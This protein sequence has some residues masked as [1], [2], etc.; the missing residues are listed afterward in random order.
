MKSVVQFLGEVRT[1][2]SK[3]DW[4]KFND[5]VGS[6]VI[7]LFLVVVFAVF[8]GSVDRLITMAAKQIFSYGG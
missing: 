3:I 7:V 1:E 5:F 4:P 6:T 2:L 8:L